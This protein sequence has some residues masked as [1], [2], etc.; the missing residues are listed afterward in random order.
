MTL[1]RRVR[2][3]GVLLCCLDLWLCKTVPAHGSLRSSRGVAV[4]R[5]DAAELD[6]LVCVA[7][8]SQKPRRAWRASPGPTATRAVRC[9]LLFQPLLLRLGVRAA[10]SQVSRFCSG[11]GG[12]VCRVWE[13]KR[14]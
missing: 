12:L 14:Y 4:V 3:E 10:A 11:E 9:A 7:S 8:L 6:C 13:S 5:V 1:I 2:H